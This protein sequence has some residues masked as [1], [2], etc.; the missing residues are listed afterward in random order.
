[1][2]QA[3]DALQGQLDDALKQAQEQRQKLQG[4][5]KEVS[6]PSGRCLLTRGRLTRFDASA[7]TMSC[8]CYA[9]TEQL[10]QCDSV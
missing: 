1:M 10:N 6:R 5:L 3:K 2:H 8:D 9:Y 7:A 4:R